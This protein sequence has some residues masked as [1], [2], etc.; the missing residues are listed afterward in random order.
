MNTLMMYPLLLTRSEL[1]TDHFYHHDWY[2]ICPDCR[3][4]DRSFSPLVF[5]LLGFPLAVITNRREK[6]ANV[7]MAILC[8]AAYYL[9]SLGCE[10]LSL[11]GF[12]APHIILWVPNVLA[13]VGALILNIKC[14][15]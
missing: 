12:V 6:S 2:I 1:S 4:T 10:A 5:I 8:A 13:L 15:S 7:V 3:I 14:A 11:K 9:V